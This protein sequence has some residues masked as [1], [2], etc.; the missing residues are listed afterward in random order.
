M[1]VCPWHIKEPKLVE[2][3]AD[4]KK[5]LTGDPSSKHWQALKSLLIKTE[6]E[7]TAGIKYLEKGPPGAIP[8]GIAKPLRR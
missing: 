2:E 5:A 3:I 8:H 1:A 6:N 4:L 7:L